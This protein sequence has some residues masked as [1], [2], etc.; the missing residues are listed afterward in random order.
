[1]N[2]M[3]ERVAEA[4]YKTDPVGVRPWQDAPISNRDDCLACA[5]AAIA[6]MREPTEAMVEAG[7]AE[8]YE[9]HEKPEDWTLENTKT[10]WMMMIDAA[11]ADQKA[12]TE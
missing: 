9:H 7:E 4:I 10:A 5:R 6:A 1:M 11:L 2:E 3:V 12:E 8:M